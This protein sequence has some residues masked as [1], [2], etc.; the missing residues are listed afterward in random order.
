[1]RIYSILVL[2]SLFL[3][4]DIHAQI[5]PGVDFDLNGYIN[6]KL[7]AGETYI[8]VPPGRYRVPEMNNTHLRFTGRNDVTIVADGVEMICTE[9]VQAI[10][11]V[12]CNNFKLQ[13]LTIDYDPLPFTQG[14]IVELSSNKRTLTVDLI[15]GYSSRL[16]GDK[17]EIFDPNTGELVTNTYYGATYE[18]DDETRKVIITKPSNYNAVDSQEEVG[19]IVVL[20]SQSN[21]NIPHAILPSSC[22]NL[23]LENVTL[24][25]GTT[26][27]FFETNCSGSKYINCSVDRRPLETDIRE[28]GVRRMRSNNADGFH[29][30]FARV[31][32]SYVGC[33]SRYNGDDG[34]A[35][36]GDYHVVTAAVG[37]KLTVVAKGG[38]PLRLDV[39][40]SVELVTYT[41]KRLPNANVV[42]IEMGPALT[43][44]EKGFLQG[45]T[46]YAEAADTYKA[47][48]VY[49]VTIDRPINMQRGSLLAAANRIGNS[50]EVRDCIMGPNRSR[51]ILIKSSNGII[52]GN[53]LKDN[54]GQAIKLAPEY[55]WL[56]SG[57]G[58]NITVSDNVISGCH[59]VSIAVYATGGNGQVAPIGA[60]EN[61]QII[62]NSIVGST[63]PAIAITSTRNFTLENNTISSP[64]NELLAPWISGNFGRNAD[65]DREIY[66]DNFEV[67]DVNVSGISIGNCIDDYIM[68]GDTYDLNHTISPGN[69]TYK[70]VRWSSSDTS[71]VTVDERGVVTAVSDG[72]ATITVTSNDGNFSSECSINSGTEPV[73]LDSHV[74]S[75]ELPS[76]YPNPSYGR[77]FFRAAEPDDKIYI[78]SIAGTLIDSLVYDHSMSIELNSGIYV[79]KIIS[80]SGQESSHKVVIKK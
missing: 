15:D 74:S 11:I 16:R 59:D 29:S 3:S 44:Q 53:T 17:V 49:Y 9:T 47:R 66:F 24:Y 55:V 4:F 61:I 52:T 70:G 79:V 78:Y 30:K 21:K 26:F 57:S 45:T 51:G 40:D 31:G 25:A 35:I 67:E 19:D 73:I 1:M 23:V 27:G 72:N 12:S 7:D 65:P 34:I 37:P 39:G 68:L 76:I 18:V 36:N 69:A 75:I 62:G 60:H 54:W 41:G 58:S 46:F 71:I 20:G 5:D 38:G 77:I 56:E 50:F 22:T 8:V 64:N 63:N 10:Q 6:E 2:F 43:A 13:G 48:F 28:R 33:I 14:R 80:Q 32:P 42:E